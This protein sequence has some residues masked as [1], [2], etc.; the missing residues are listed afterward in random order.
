MY[1]SG[2]TELRTYVY[3]SSEGE[4]YGINSLINNNKDNIFE[5]SLGQ[6]DF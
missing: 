4:K 5:K 6:V 2:L 3:L 1:K